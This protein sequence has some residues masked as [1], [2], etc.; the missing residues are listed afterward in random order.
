MKKRTQLSLVM[1]S[2]A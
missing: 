2:V 1:T